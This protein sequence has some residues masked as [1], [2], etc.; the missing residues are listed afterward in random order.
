MRKSV[1]RVYDHVR[2]NRACSAAEGSLNI[3]ILNEAS[4]S[5]SLQRVDTKG[6]DGQAC[7]CLIWSHVTNSFFL[8]TRS[9]YFFP[10]ENFNPY[11]PS[12][13]FVGHWKTVQS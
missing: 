4:L 6:A 1:F 10:V 2:L 13:L 9:I 8:V 7:L 3:K 5:H 12:V 11:K